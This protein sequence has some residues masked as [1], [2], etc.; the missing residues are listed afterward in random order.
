MV[1]CNDVRKILGA[2]ELGV[3]EGN[4]SLLVEEHLLHC[5][6][7]FEELYETAPLLYP[8]GRGRKKIDPKPRRRWRFAL[9]VAASIVV[10]VFSSAFLLE[11]DSSQFRSG[12]PY[13]EEI[14]FLSPRDSIESELVR[15]RWDPA[16]DVDM[17]TL[18]IFDDE[19][20]PVLERQVVGTETT[21][22]LDREGLLAS[23]VTY[24]WKVVGNHSG[25]E[26]GLPSKIVTFSVPPG[27]GHR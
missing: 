4:E 26:T 1:D 11:D 7:C 10:V 2:Y 3:L 14:R 23:D 15:F 12:L 17:Y 24:H 9:A 22:N 27:L 8:F 25:T 19:G 6:D 20:T 5:D 16:T 18:V 21:V 13:D